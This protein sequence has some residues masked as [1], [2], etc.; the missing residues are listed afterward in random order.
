[1]AAPYILARTLREAHAFARETLGL[2]VGHYRIV[3]SAGTLKSVR[4]VDLYLVPG[5]QQRYDRFAMK[6]TLRWTRMNVI[7]A[8]KQPVEAPADPRGDLT[9]E[10]Y[11]MA[12]AEHEARGFDLPEPSAEEQAR[13]QG[14]LDGLTPSGVQ[15]SFDELFEHVDTTASQG[16]PAQPEPEAEPE[17]PA[18]PEAEAPPV[19]RRRRRCKECGI[20]VEPD[21]VDQHREDHKNDLVGV[22]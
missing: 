14:I 13:V 16:S 1:M 18:E 15:M 10:L 2:S 8:E 12:Y 3:N 9:D 7:D 20:L 5:W 21:D 19:K 22:Q 17:T 4:G 6:S 11:C